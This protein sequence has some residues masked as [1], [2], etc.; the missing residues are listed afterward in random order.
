VDKSK[1]YQLQELFTLN[2]MHRGKTDE[3]F[4]S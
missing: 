4:E 3:I 1:D 2:M